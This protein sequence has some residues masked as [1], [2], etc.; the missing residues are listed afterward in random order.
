VPTSRR[1][2]FRVVVGLVLP[3]ATIVTAAAHYGCSF[4]GGLA[5]GVGLGFGIALVGVLAAVVVVRR[6]TRQTLNP[7]RP[8]C[9]HRWDY[10]MELMG[11]DGR[12][13]YG[14]SFRGRV[15]FLNFWATWCVP[16]VAEMPSIERLL[17][18]IAD[19]RIV[20]VCVTKESADSVKAFLAKRGLSLPVYCCDKRPEFFDTSSLPA[21]F[22][23]AS[24]GTICFR[25]EGAARW[26]S[27]E[28]I[29]FLRRLATEVSPAA[30]S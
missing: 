22:V 1:S 18:V 5:V 17:S 15:L 23:V 12:Y 28:M 13:L 4:A 8:R 21:T 16:C 24:D 10:D 11:L 27:D 6:Q 2:S 29:V 7:V 3:C 20:F 30:Q 9:L 19:P 14:S 26:D 25:R